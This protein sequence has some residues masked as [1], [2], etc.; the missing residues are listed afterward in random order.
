MF[1]CFF[2]DLFQTLRAKLKYLLLSYTCIKIMQSVHPKC[3][4]MFLMDWKTKFKNLWL[5]FV[6]T[7]IWKTKLYF[8]YWLFN[9]LIRFLFSWQ[10]ETKYNLFFVFPFLWRNWKTNYLTRSRLTL[11]LFAQV[12][13]TFYSKASLY[14]VPWDFPLCNCH[15]DT[16]NSLFRKQLMYFN[17]L[18]DKAP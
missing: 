6:F 7:S 18:W 12:W 1:V 5:D 4:F 11:R 15:A 17:Q 16:K 2:D 8:N 14:Q 13:F 10:M 3:C 9:A